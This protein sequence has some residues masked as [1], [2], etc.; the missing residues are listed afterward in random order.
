MAVSVA[1]LS[2]VAACAS[3]ATPAA[4]VGGGLLRT[5][6]P[7]P[8]LRGTTLDGT[9]LD[10]TQQYA[11]KVVVINFYASW[12]SPCRE[13]T[14]LLVRAAKANA[15]DG[16]AFAGVLFKDSATNGRSFRSTFAVT[17]PSLVDTDG[18]FLAGFKGV[19][20]SAIP[21][22]FVLNRAGKVAARWIGGV[23]DEAQFDQVLHQLAAAPAA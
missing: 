3:S 17:W 4:Q 12:C 23:H 18:V 22:T 10:L 14:P 1:A 8:Q 7:A 21:D 2:L 15:T 16:V 19:N 11:G 13:E 20:A 9:S 5:P 6:Q